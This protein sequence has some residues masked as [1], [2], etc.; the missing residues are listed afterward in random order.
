MNNTERQQLRNAFVLLKVDTSQSPKSTKTNDKGL[1]H[2]QSLAL[3]AISPLNELLEKLN[4][5]ETDV[6]PEEV[7]YMVESAITVLGNASSQVSGLCGQKVLEEYNKDLLS[8]H[9]L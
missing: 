1:A 5:E 2:V 7:G 9:P 4:L 8:F 3:D 6:M